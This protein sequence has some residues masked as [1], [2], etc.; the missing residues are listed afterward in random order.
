MTSAIEK[1]FPSLT[2]QQKNDFAMLRGLYSHWNESINVI[3][4]K[5]IE[6]FDVNHLLHSLAVARFIP[7][8]P[9]TEVIDVGTGGGLPGIPLAVMFPKVE[10]T[11]IDSVGKKIKVVNEIVS[12]LGLRNVTAVTSRSED[13]TGRYDFVISRAVTDMSRFVSM[14]RHLIAPR[15][16]NAVRN[17]YIFLKGGDLEQ[18]LKPFSGKITVAEISEWFDEP[19]FKTKKIVFLPW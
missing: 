12:A 13:F 6:N 15:S 11:L 7:F 3:S 17:G 9:Q 4:R 5:D 16:F 8:A 14:T 1:Y 10:F 19:Y 18:E 2:G